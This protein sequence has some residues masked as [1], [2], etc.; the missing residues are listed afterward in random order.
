MSRRPT[1]KV[2]RD[3]VPEPKPDFTNGSYLEQVSLGR[4][5][6]TAPT[7]D[8]EE[9]R[10]A[11]QT[12]AAYVA[13]RAERYLFPDGATE[14]QRQ[15]FRDSL[16]SSYS[17]GFCLALL[18]YRDDLRGSKEAMS[19]LNAR[20]S[21]AAR[22]RETQARK[23]ADRHARIQSMLAQGIEPKD[24]ASAIP[25]SIS[26]VYRALTPPTGKPAKRSRSPRRR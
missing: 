17:R 8:A 13:R 15:R 9:L 7:R 24:I 26:T 23:K 25:C 5:L 10:V 1:K 2:W 20:D 16:E 4:W 21:G 3:P 6:D 22:G 12:L 11:F 14:Q 18:R 19:F